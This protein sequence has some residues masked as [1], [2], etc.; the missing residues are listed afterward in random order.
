MSK[1]VNELVTHSAIVIFKFRF[2]IA[3]LLVIT[4]FLNSLE[5]KILQINQ[6]IME[7]QIFLFYYSYRYMSKQ[8][9]LSY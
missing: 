8:L 9:I 6:Y 1:V 2:Y 4:G 7:V 3:S 5:N